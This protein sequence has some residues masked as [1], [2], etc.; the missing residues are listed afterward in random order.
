MVHQVADR[1]LAAP[2]PF[3]YLWLRQ[4]AVTLN[5][6]NESFPVH[7]RQYIGVTISSQQGGLYLFLVG[8]AMRSEF[9]QRL[10]EARTGAKLTQAKLAAAVGMKQ[11]TYSELEKVGQGSAYTSAIA[12]ACGVNPLWLETGIGKKELTSTSPSVYWSTN[13]DLTQAQQAQEAINLISNVSEI[14]KRP[15]VPLISMIHAGELSDVLDIFHPGE[16]VVWVEPRCSNP[17]DQAYALKVEG[18]SMESPIPGAMSIVEGSILVVDPNAA[19]SANDYVI[20]KDLA[21]QKANFRQLK[22]DGVR[23]Y[24]KPLNPAYQMIEI[25]DPEMR[26]IGRVMEIQPPV[27]KV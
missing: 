6:G 12:N 25:D 18:D 1:G 14:Q 9:G 11:P 27:I 4:F 17:S 21:T 19:A 5:F 20:A 8:F 16:A 26:V 3:G 2:D 7:E 23:W 22:T 10:F 15:R 24:L 13:S